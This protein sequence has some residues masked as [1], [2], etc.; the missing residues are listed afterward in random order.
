M[1]QARIDQRAR[2]RLVERHALALEIPD[3]LDAGVLA[4]HH[5][6]ALGIEVGDG[7]QHVD[8]QPALIDA[9]AVRG[10]KGHVR[11]DEARLHAA[12][13][14]AG[15]IGH[16]AVG[17]H[18]RGDQA[19]HAAR[20]AVGAGPRAWRVGDGVGDQA[21][22]RKVGAGRAAGADTEERD[23]LL[24]RRRQGAERHAQWRSKAAQQ[25]LPAIDPH[26]R[27]PDSPGLNR[28]PPAVAMKAGQFTPIARLMVGPISAWI[29]TSA[30]SS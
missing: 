16:R 2:A 13:G 10:P 30:S 8:L 5:V 14:D 22:Y 15:D 11:L 17:R 28:V 1:D 24:R 9:G 27:L 25:R 21:A 20:A 19:G 23:V 29:T 18:G 26:R 12:G 7:A 4:H 6:E 3:R